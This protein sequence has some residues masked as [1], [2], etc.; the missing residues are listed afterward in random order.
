MAAVNTIATLLTLALACMSMRGQTM[1]DM[2]ADAAEATPQWDAVERFG[3]QPLC[4]KAASTADLVMIPGMSARIA[5]RVLAVAAARPTWDVGRIADSLCLGLAQRLMLMLCTTT[6]CDT[7]S[8]SAMTSL[9]AS[10]RLDAA[11]RL[12]LQAGTWTLD[13]T[14]SRQPEERHTVGHVG[15]ALRW[16]TKSLTLLAGDAAIRV[17]TGLLMGNAG[18]SRGTAPT[19]LDDPLMLRPWT[20]TLRTG[21]LRGLAV[22]RDDDVGSYT[23]RSVGAFARRTLT[24]RLDTLHNVSSIPSAQPM[25]AAPA[26]TNIDLCT[27][28]VAGGAIAV[29]RPAWH[30]GLSA[31]SIRYDRPLQ[32]SSARTIIGSGGIAWSLFGGATS[33]RRSALWEAAVDTR[34]QLAFA[35]GYAIAGRRGRVAISGRHIGAGYRAP[36]GDAPGDAGAAAN[37]AGL[38][39]AGTLRVDTLT[40]VDAQLD[41]LGTFDRTYSVPRP[42][43]GYV[44]DLTAHRRMAR[45]GAAY[46]RCRLD[47]EDDAVR[48][49]GVARTLTSVRMRL[50][51]RAGLDWRIA[52]PLTVTSRMD[53]VH[54]QWSAHV[55]AMNGTAMMVRCVF[56]PVPWLRLTAQTTVYDTPGM[57]AAVYVAEAPMPSMLRMPALVG[58][59]TRTMLAARLSIAPGLTL[60][61][62]MLDAPRER[63]Y[64]VMLR[65]KLGGTVVL[66]ADQELVGG[67]LANEGLGDG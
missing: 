38:S 33:D 55:P 1:L 42:V 34:G 46:L 27:E 2:L 47:E 19:D 32:T 43:R 11:Q 64:D 39:V 18:M 49:A 14:A 9:R 66:P 61:T 48:L 59:G 15:A 29:Q 45:R 36:Y 50:R 25:F 20:S 60:W 28:T 67:H 4:L 54:A 21:F 30:V 26:A 37:L 44:T 10:S 65:W 63:R 58:S 17:G 52:S 6:R 22:M 40:R 16:H 24:V 3:E 35:G 56:V 51:M 5:T 57:D 23:V 7:M 12:S 8:W 13:A 41:I 62:S 53:V 31:W